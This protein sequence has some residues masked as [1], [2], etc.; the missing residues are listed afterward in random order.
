MIVSQFSMLGNLEPWPWASGI[1]FQLRPLPG[2]VGPLD[3]HDPVNGATHGSFLTTSG[4]VLGSRLFG[5]KRTHPG[6]P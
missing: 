6:L 4:I 5:A 1:Q 3:E 2:H